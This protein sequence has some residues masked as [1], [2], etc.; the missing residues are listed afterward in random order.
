MH[1]V[2]GQQHVAFH[3]A[4]VIEMCDDRIAPVLDRTEAFAVRDGYASPT[5]FLQQDLV[6]G[7]AENRDA[8]SRSAEA[9]PAERAAVVVPKCELARGRAGRLYSI[10]E[11]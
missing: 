1:A 6:E 4:A 10:A 11:A 5:G 8:E 9:D 3:R 2:G 7:R